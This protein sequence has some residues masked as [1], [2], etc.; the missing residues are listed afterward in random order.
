[1]PIISANVSWLIFAITGSGLAFLA[2]VR[3]QQEQPGKT[4][5]ARIEQLID[6]VC[7]DAESSAKKMR[8]MPVPG[9]S[10]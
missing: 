5:F 9:S 6:K 10:E 1:V 4:L 3:Q 2:K 8:R 7:F